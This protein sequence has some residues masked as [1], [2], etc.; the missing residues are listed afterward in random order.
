MNPD[1]LVSAFTAAG[2][3]TLEKVQALLTTLNIQTQIAQIDSQLAAIGPKQAN[4]NQ[5]FQDQRTQ[6]NNQR[7]VLVTKLAPGP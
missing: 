6:L 1:D 7:A 2:F 4:A 3:D 5:P